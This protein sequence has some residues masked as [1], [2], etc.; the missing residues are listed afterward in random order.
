MADPDKQKDDPVKTDDSTTPL[1]ER[2]EQPYDALDD[3]KAE[4]RMGATIRAMDSMYRYG[5]STGTIIAAC[6]G[7]AYLVQNWWSE[8]RTRI[9]FELIRHNEPHEIPSADFLASSKTNCDNPNPEEQSLMEFMQTGQVRA[10]RNNLKNLRTSR[11][12]IDGL[13]KDDP[14]FGVKVDAANFIAAGKKTLVPKLRENAVDMKGLFRD[15]ETV[16]KVAIAKSMK[17][18]AAKYDFKANVEDISPADQEQAAIALIRIRQT[19]EKIRTI[20]IDMYNEKKINYKLK[21]QLH[22]QGLDKQKLES[23]SIEDATK[24]IAEIISS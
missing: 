10:P 20:L 8:D 6:R 18:M 13:L 11:E 21:K 7:L 19:L 3:K 2:D 1:P 4:I 9:L 15:M 17:K 22:L 23:L 14:F 12:S 16:F 24:T 5:G